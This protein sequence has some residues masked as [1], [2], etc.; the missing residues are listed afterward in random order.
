M[1][2][3]MQQ[4]LSVAVQRGNM[5]TRSNGIHGGHH[6]AFDNCPYNLVFFKG[7]GHM[8]PFY[9]TDLFLLLQHINLAEATF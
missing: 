1:Y 6:L 7:G 3:C 9:P 4:C 8:P 5:C 2:Q